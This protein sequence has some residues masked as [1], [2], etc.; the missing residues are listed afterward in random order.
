MSYTEWFHCDQCD[1]EF[2]CEW[3]F[4][5]DVKCS[6]CGTI[7]E[8]DYDESVDSVLGPWLVRRKQ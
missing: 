1:K 5:D 3:G 8:T 2:T 6:N 7:W 4:G